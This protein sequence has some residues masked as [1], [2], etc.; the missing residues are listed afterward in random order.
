MVV[1]KYQSL[2]RSLY[3]SPARPDLRY[4]NDDLLGAGAFRFIRALLACALAAKTDLGGVP[5]LRVD[6]GSP[7][8]IFSFF[9]ERKTDEYCG[10]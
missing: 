8:N 4:K 5:P 3:I 10:T 6:G 1:Y 7:R 9:I 2:D